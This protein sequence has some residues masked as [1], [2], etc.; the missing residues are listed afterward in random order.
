MVLLYPLLFIVA[1]ILCI[2]LVYGLFLLGAALL[3]YPVAKLG[4]VLLRLLRTKSDA[5]QQVFL[6]SFLGGGTLPYLVSQ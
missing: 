1:I 4:N 3:L 6:L 5:T 2:V